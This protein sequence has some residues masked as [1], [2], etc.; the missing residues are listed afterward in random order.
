[1]A[2]NVMII[3]VHFICLWILIPQML[4]TLLYLLWFEI[5]T[6]NRNSAFIVYLRESCFEASYALIARS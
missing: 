5:A 3:S 2:E 4:A 1:M 6:L